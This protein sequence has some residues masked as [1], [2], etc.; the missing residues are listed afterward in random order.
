MSERVAEITAA[1]LER[2][3]ASEAPIAVVDVRTPEQY[4][5]WH[6]TT[7][8]A[9]LVNVPAEELAADPT[10]LT[11][12]AA[13]REVRLICNRGKTSL[14]AARALAD[15]GV[16]VTSVAGGMVAWSQLLV[17]QEVPGTDAA[18]V[19][20]FRRESRGCLSYLVAVGGAALVVDPAVIIAPYREVADRLGVVIRDVVDTHVH[21]DHLSGAHALCAATGATR[22]VGLGA[23][24]RG[25][26]PDD[27]HALVDG[28]ELLG[29]VV[30]VRELPGHTSDNIGLIVGATALIAGDSLFAESVARP[31][32]EA[33]D[34]GIDDATKQLYH[35]I[36]ERILP[37]GDDVLLL[38]CHYPGGRRSEPIA[39]RLGDVRSAVAFLVELGLEE[40]VVE[41]RRAMPPRPANYTDIIAANLGQADG[42]LAGLE[43]GANNC[44]ASGGQ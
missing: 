4:A 35:T 40:F 33:D 36:H 39:P 13:G 12:A 21:A 27:V 31:D 18:T 11:Q 7:G 30:R 15:A 6:I 24:A 37:L 19:M 5:E 10:R 9:P 14:Q 22:H 16:R 2:E 1:E 41:V 17:S 20:Q 28:D 25:V 26:A 29:G 3:I 42:D 43:V 23:I 34:S 38:P 32:L 8:H 44:A